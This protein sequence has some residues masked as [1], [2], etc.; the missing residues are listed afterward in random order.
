MESLKGPREKRA[1]AER[2]KTFLF[3]FHPLPP[4]IVSQ[5]GETTAAGESGYER[6]SEH[7]I[8]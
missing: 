8:A 1:S 4:R 7:G 2:K 6:A 5:L 3:L